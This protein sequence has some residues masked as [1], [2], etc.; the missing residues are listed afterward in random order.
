M[1]FRID[2]NLVKAVNKAEPA[3][4]D[5]VAGRGS[6]KLTRGLAMLPRTAAIMTCR[7]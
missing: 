5:L 6:A 4:N 1:Q 2:S 7:Y 3:A